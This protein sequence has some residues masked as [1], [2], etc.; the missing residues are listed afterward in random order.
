MSESSSIRTILIAAIE[1][2]G[3]LLVMGG[4]L[5]L[6]LHLLGRTDIPLL[7]AA[8]FIGLGIAALAS[9]VLFG[10]GYR[11]SLGVLATFAFYGVALGGIG[12][13]LQSESFTAHAGIIVLTLVVGFAGFLYLGRSGSQK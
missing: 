1:L 4:A 7:R 9:V 3:G 11:A 13:I 5:A 6:T 2:I 10:R 8:L 12:I